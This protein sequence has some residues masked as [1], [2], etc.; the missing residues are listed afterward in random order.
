MRHASTTVASGTT[1]TA[2]T[3]I[4]IIIIAFYDFVW[5]HDAS[6]VVGSFWLA[7]SNF[8]R[9]RN[10]ICNLSLHGAQRSAHTGHHW[11]VS[12][13]F[14]ET[15]NEIE[16]DSM[17]RR[18]LFALASSARGPCHFQCQREKQRLTRM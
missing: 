14:S 13:F 1:A 10:E 3:Q 11:T 4:V 5:F 2:A 9:R 16:I 7:F 18:I 15:N 8:G 17:V 6:T 12:T